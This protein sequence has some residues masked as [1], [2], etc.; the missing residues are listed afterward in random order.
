MTATFTKVQAQQAWT[1]ARVEMRRAF[2]SKRA[3]WV[4]LL[5]LFPAAAFLAYGLQMKVMEER[6]ARHGLASAQLIDSFT[7]GEKVEDVLE[8]AP[9]PAFD[10]KWKNWRDDEEEHEGRNREGKAREGKDRKER[11]EE[12]VERRALTYF[13]GQ[14]VADLRFSNG[15]LD[16]KSVHLILE[17][18]EDRKIFAG[19]FQ[20]FYLRLAIFFGCLGIF[21]NMFR[22]ELLDK[23]LHFWFLMP[24]RREV[25][26]AGKY[27]AGL[28]AA[29]VIFG[30]GALLG[31]GAMLW[32]HS[33]VEAQMFLAGAGWSHAF[34]Y[35]AAA[36]LGCLGYG[37]V[38][39]A[40][41]LLL[42]NPIIP[43]AV[44]LLW[45]SING[46]LPATLQK[47]SVLYYLQSLCPETAPLDEGPPLLRLLLAPAAPA[48]KGLA[49]AGLILVTALVLW[50]ASRAVKKIE[51]N[52][53]TD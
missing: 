12:R 29:A 48:S 34:W 47:L 17:L 32:P 42:R 20:Y 26:L 46:F 28:T 23:T 25:L 35:A 11:E 4:Y 52:Y 13:D 49:I 45:E 2:L 27:I 24:V 31:Y 30:G 6:W 44:I 50:A 51:I 15:V 40:A 33:G 37:S 14:R 39:L 36:V 21:M 7:K 5:A 41:G 38:F 53:S 3:L 16:E 22:G 1:I 10:R 8:R 9:N 19:I 18:S 43:A